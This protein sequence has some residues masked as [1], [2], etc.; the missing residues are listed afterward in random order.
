ML[1]FLMNILGL[2]FVLF[3]FGLCIFLHELGHLLVAYW[4][5]LHIERFSIGFGPAIVKWRKWDIDFQLSWLPFGG[6]VALPQLDPSEVPQTFAG[7]PLPRAKPV[8]RILTALAGPIMN[9]VLGV[10][11]ALVIWKVGI[12]GSPPSD[13]FVLADVPATY[14]DAEK[15]DR[16]NPEYEAGLRAGDRVVEI[17]E[18][19]VSRG[20]RDGVRRIIYAPGNEVSII[21]EREG[22]RQEANY[23]SA[24]NPYFEG[25]GVPFMQPEF[26]VAVKGVIR[27][28]PAEQ[29]GLKFGDI[30]LS[31]DGAPVKSMKDLIEGVGAAGG[32]AVS[33]EVDRRGEVIGLS[34]TPRMHQPE[35]ETEARPMIGIQMDYGWLY[36][37]SPWMQV[38][39]AVTESFYTLRAV[40]DPDNSIK[41]KHMSGP[42]GILNALWTV[43][44][45]DSFI[46]GLRLLILI[47]FSLA[48]I[49]L[50]P[51]PVLDGGHIAFAVIEMV[52]RRPVPAKFA[53]ALSNAF[54]LL[55]LCFMVY[56]TAQDIGRLRPEPVTAESQ[57]EVVAPAV[58]D[59]EPETE[60]EPEPVP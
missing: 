48:I 1:E 58:T 20:W 9:M 21:F 30:I 7:D 57:G 25:V 33:L 37:P 19:P 32:D 29:A 41:P 6:Y 15:I 35:K 60:P 11:L 54:V 23:V 13:S 31:I 24:P 42:V 39:D 46:Q 5:G 50:L 3:F 16:K 47:N 45:R 28:M 43:V 26:P 8:D 40:A 18:E 14:K 12:I 52:A 2:A 53:I 4:R 36:N 59:P 17:N 38:C 34:L 55:L 51:L 27:D 44:S 10:C 49:N 22:E 56:V